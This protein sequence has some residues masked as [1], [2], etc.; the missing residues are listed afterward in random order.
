MIKLLSQHQ[1]ETI[2]ELAKTDI[3]LRYQGSFL[4][5]FWVF[6]KPL[7]I[8][9]V[10]NFVFSSYFDH[11]PN[12]PIRLL[13]GIILWSLFSDA[14]MKG[15]T[16][17][18]TKTHILKKIFMPKWE[19]VLASI[20]H[21]AIVFLFNLIILFLFLFFFYQIF[22][23]P[24]YLAMFMFYIFQIYLI[25]L[26]FSLFTATIYVRLRDLDQI[27]EVLLRILFYATPI[28]FPIDI[29]PD[30]V[31]KWV[32]LNPMTFIIERSRSVLIDQQII[33]F[34]QDVVFTLILVFALIAGI[35][36]FKSNSRFLVEKM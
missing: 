32:Y 14:T 21:S 12:Y 5:I 30:N 20:L 27:W 17:L 16:S 13:T 35:M 8:F 10:L 23:S 9:A 25:S 28:I 15:M 24:L 18:V 29:L 7:G 1:R 4:G 36:F 19:I 33:N 3:K 31:R 6:L 26:A 22:P 11:T 2:W 34:S